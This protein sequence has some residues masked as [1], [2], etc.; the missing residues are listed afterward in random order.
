MGLDLNIIYKYLTILSGY[1]SIK[2]T[3]IVN[4][5]QSYII[6]NY[7]SLWGKIKHTFVVT[8]RE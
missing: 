8:R 2:L 3:L 7:N 5:L 1:L 4:Y 6:M